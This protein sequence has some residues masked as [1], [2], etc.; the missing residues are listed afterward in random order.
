MSVR[1]YWIALSILTVAAVSPA[2][3]AHELDLRTRVDAQVEIRRFYHEHRIGATGAFDAAAARVA[4]TRRVL[5]GLESTERPSDDEIDREL[6]RIERQTRFPQRLRELFAA[7]AD[8]PVLIREA[9]VVPLLIERRRFGADA[10]RVGLDATPAD[11]A[12]AVTGNGCPETEQ[13][14][15][16]SLAMAPS[17]RNAHTLTWTGTEAIVW[18]GVG[19]A[20]DGARYDPMLDAWTGI[21]TTDAPSPRGGHTAVWTGSEMIVWGGRSGTEWLR[22]GAR[23]DPSLDAWTPIDATAAPAGRERHTAVWTGA[24]MIVYGGEAGPPCDIPLGDGAA[25]DP[26]TDGWQPLPLPPGGSDPRS[27][28]TAVWTGSEMIVWGGRTSADV[29]QCIHD[30]R[31]D[32]WVYDPDPGTWAALPS[33]PPGRYR[34]TAVWTGSDMIVW[35]GATPAL[36]S[37]DPVSAIGDGARFRPAANAWLPMS[38]SPAMLERYDHTAVWSGNEM[39]VWGGRAIEQVPGYDVG[40]GR[41]DPVDDAWRTVTDQGEPPL[42]SDHAAIWTG[43]AMIVW[44]GT[45]PTAEGGVYR[46]PAPD[47]DGDGLCAFE[48]NCPVDYNPDQGDV[49][50]DARGDAC[51]PCPADPANDGDQDGSC[52][53]ADNCPSVNNPDQSDVDFDG[54]G[55]ACDN[56]PAVANP[57]QGDV[58]GDGFGD[59]C[60]T[61]PSISDPSQADADADGAGDPCDNCVLLANASQTD[62]DADGVGNACDPCP[63]AVPSP[64]RLSDEGHDVRDALVTPDGTRAVYRQ[65][66]TLHTSNLT[67]AP[68]I[69]ETPPPAVVADITFF[70]VSPDSETIVFAQRRDD[71]SVT[72]LYGV[73]TD[74]GAVTRLTPPASGSGAGL[75]SPPGDNVRF[76]AGGQRVVYRGGFESS[77]SE[78]Y[79]ATIDGSDVVKLNK[80]L[81]SGSVRSSDVSPDGQDIVYI[82][83]QDTAGVNELYAR[84]VTGSGA[85]PTLNGPLVAGGDVTQAAFLPDGRVVY[86]ADQDTDGVIDLF[87]RPLTGGGAALRI[88]GAAS[89][90]AGFEISSTGEWIAF[91]GT[92]SGAAGFFAVR[93][94]GSDLHPVGGPEAEVFGEVDEFR[95]NATGTHLVYRAQP[96][97]FG[98]HHVYAAEIVTGVST[99]LDPDLGPTVGVADRFVSSP[100]GTV[101]AFRVYTTP[102]SGELWAASIDGSQAL[103]M[104]GGGSADDFAFT[105]DSTS[106]L[107]RQRDPSGF[108]PPFRLYRGSTAIGADGSRLVGRPDP[109]R[110]GVQRFEVAPAGDSVVYITREPLVPPELLVAPIGPDADGDLVLDA[111]DCRAADGTVFA[112]AS[113]ETT[114]VSFDAAGVVSWESVAEAFGAGTGYH[115]VRGDTTDLPVG[116]PSESCLLSGEAETSIALPNAPPPGTCWYFIVRPANACG[117]GSF[118]FADPVSIGERETS[119]CQ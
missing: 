93:P 81:E 118:G 95:F 72:D 98:V 106:L 109:G 25:Y 89:L 31:D 60:D 18:G 36:L 104:S 101:V 44:G 119:V 16:T 57:S 107:F 108:D 87:V 10:R 88:N 91:H 28:H 49:D 79:S 38:T 4:A 69:A 19:G 58:D 8:D 96:D 68:T 54:D 12:R 32:G 103:R 26:G 112:P 63:I 73:P 24:T 77:S 92:L 53:G 94:D 42:N 11:R 70:V 9:L 100:D 41:Y 102:T 47:D 29:G 111:C 20:A 114:F 45:N 74:G 105:S 55:D 40:N 43:S 67:G 3:V 50:A 39:I 80:P 13:W 15:P 110:P 5:R 116:G 62:L 71:P 51:D 64:V 34:H 7:L 85:N 33:G 84:A 14:F 113:G 76:A 22:T 59:A 90:S 6:A 46:A 21:S 17:P 65:L 30:V 37:P 99:R 27:D 56:C 2:V 35:G 48:D 52:A 1:W 86:A 83:Q 75:P 115:L 78:L 23:Y 66:R 61:C 117:S 82:A 97:T